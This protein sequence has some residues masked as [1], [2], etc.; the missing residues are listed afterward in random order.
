MTKPKRNLVATI[1]VGLILFLITFTFIPIKIF[2]APNILVVNST[3][4]PGDGACTT[5]HCTL[6]EAITDAASGDT[7]NFDSSIWSETILLG[8]ELVID[9]DITIEQKHK[10]IFMTISGGDST[11]LFYVNGNKSLTLKKLILIDGLGNPS[12]GAVYNFMGDVTIVNCRFE[13]NNTT[14]AYGGALY[15]YDMGTMVVERS[16][17]TSN[18]AKRGGAIWN[19][20]TLTVT[21]SEFEN[22]SAEE[23]GGGIYNNL[24]ADGLSIENS[25]FIGNTTDVYGGGAVYNESP[26]PLYITNSTFYGNSAGGSGGGLYSYSFS[27]PVIKN[28]TFFDNSGSISGEGAGVHIYNAPLS[29]VNTIIANSTGGYDCYKDSQGTPSEYNLIMNNAPYPYNCGYPI[30]SSGPMLQDPPAYNHPETKTMALLSGSPA[31]DVGN[32]TLCPDTDQRG[33]IRPQGG[34]CDLGAYELDSYPTVLATGPA[35]PNPT[36]EAWVEF[37]VRFNEPVTGVDLTDF[38]LT[39]TGAIVGTD[40]TEVVGSGDV[41]TLTVR[42]G[43]NTG[44]IR[45][46]VMDDDSIVDNAPYPLGGRDPGNGNFTFGEV[47]YVRYEFVYL[48]LVIR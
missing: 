6:R 26:N 21:D 40:I 30:L 41:Y 2:S 24:N 43:S 4:D 39:T 23:R 3:A 9:K 48:P 34:G 14:T 37:T 11:R 5:G 7:I 27:E 32:S 44:T 20:G 13:G 10:T 1:I 18:T 36:N 19:F 28:C 25:T 35:G 12:G 38:T 42:T 46:D 33:F 31:I 45:L 29:M 15:N 22:N 8:S 17:F 16:K 47:L